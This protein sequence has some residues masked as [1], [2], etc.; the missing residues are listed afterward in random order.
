MSG[1]KKL[2]DKL[3]RKQA[4]YI[5]TYNIKKNPLITFG[6]TSGKVC[7]IVLP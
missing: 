7:G 6:G 3:C 1:E 4:K 5:F 2:G